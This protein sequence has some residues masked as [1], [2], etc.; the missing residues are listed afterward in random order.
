V[1]ADSA[2]E[3]LNG[4]RSRPGQAD[5]SEVGIGLDFLC[6]MRLHWAASLGRGAQL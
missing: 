6:P 2:S 4:L 3:G 5:A 1:I